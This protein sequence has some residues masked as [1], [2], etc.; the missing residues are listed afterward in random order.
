LRIEFDPDA[1]TTTRGSNGKDNPVILAARL[2][3]V[4][5]PKED[6]KLGLACEEYSRTITYSSNLYSLSLD[7]V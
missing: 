5:S 4:H 1:G 6:L 7:Y 3:Y 2:Y